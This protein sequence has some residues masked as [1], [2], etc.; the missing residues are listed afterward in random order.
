MTTRAETAKILIPVGDIV[1]KELITKALHVLSTF[2]SPI[3]V[4][5]HV[6]EI[7]SR[8]A[9]LET[10]PYEAQIKSAEKRLGDIST[11][12]TGQGLEVRIKVAIARYIAEGIIDEVNGDGYLVVFLMKRKMAKGWKRLFTRS[13]SERVIRSVNCLVMIATL[14]QL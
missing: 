11:W 7:P 8:T 13:V 1:S 10:E 4:L 9:T 6:I 2:K 3:I 12:L 14:E 5:F